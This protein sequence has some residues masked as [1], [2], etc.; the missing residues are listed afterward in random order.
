MKPVPSTLVKT[1]PQRG[2][3]QQFRFVKATAFR[4][5][6]CGDTK[7][8]KLITVYGDDWSRRLCNGCYGCLLS[9]YDVMS[10]TKSDYERSEDLLVALLSLVAVDERRQVERLYR[11]VEKR[12]DRLSPESV[13]FIATAEHVA[14]RLQS[15][16]YL[17]WSPAVIGMC[18]AVESEIV[19]RILIPLADMT[20]SLDLTV[21]KGDKDL[22]PVAAFCA[23]PSRKSPELGTFAHFLQT[24]IHSRRRRQSSVLIGSFLGLI[25]NWPGSNWL[26]DPNS[27]H[28]SICALTTTFRNR[29]AHVDELGRPDY[30]GC[31]DL[32]I[33]D[34]GIVW[35]LLVASETHK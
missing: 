23:E 5:F 18:K 35:N 29:A 33:G 27:L 1:Y 10:G 3:L 32:V 2:P 15:E 21:D 12:A 22:G 11:A 19:N 25:A 20:G 8:S 7:K 26:L 6:R 14:E 9:L 17:E 31:R 4:C 16:P 24:V 28:Q 13:R 30:L 34:Q